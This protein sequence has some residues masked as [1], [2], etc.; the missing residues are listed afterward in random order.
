MSEPTKAN[1]QPVV[2]GSLLDRLAPPKAQRPKKP[3]PTDRIQFSKQLDIL[4]TYAALSP[5]GVKG[6]TNDEIGKIVR[7]KGS[8]VSL[9]NP[10]LCEIGLLVKQ[11]KGYAPAPDVLSYQRAAEWA[12]EK[13]PEKLAPTIRQT[14]FA[15]KLLPH[16]VLNQKIDEKE[17]LAELASEAAVSP[18]RTK[19]LKILLDFMEVSK[20]IE[21]DGQTLR[22]GPLLRENGTVA[23][24]PEPND[25]PEKEMTPPKGPSIATSFLTPTEGVVQ[26]HVSVKVDMAEF[27][28]WKAD[29]IAAFFGGIAQVLAAKGQIEED[30]ALSES[31]NS[32]RPG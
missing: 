10:F 5:T 14:W 21:R 18:G 31:H 13:A 27:S 8:T 29:R 24:R 16:L 3:L 4:R 1:G 28:G 32:K 12:P 11:G 26:F 25:G 19:Q 30:E 23:S 17:A 20:I 7:M 9:A 22:V 2:A 15:Q 6:L